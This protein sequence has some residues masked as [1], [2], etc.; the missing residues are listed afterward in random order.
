[1]TKGLLLFLGWSLLT[2]T[3]VLFAVNKANSLLRGSGSSTMTSVNLLGL[4]IVYSKSIVG[5]VLKGS[6][7]DVC[8]LVRQVGLIQVLV[9]PIQY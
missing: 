6:A 9:Q 1:V 5:V 4:E 3:I 7:R 8:P 2:V